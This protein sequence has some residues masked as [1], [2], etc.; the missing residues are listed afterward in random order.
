MIEEAVM[1]RYRGSQR[2]SSTWVD[3]RSDF[4]QPSFEAVRSCRGYGFLTTTLWLTVIQ[5]APDL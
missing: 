1:E 4:F 3:N 2:V 5:L